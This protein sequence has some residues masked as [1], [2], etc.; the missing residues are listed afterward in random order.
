MAEKQATKKASS[1]TAKNQPETGNGYNVQP[2]PFDYLGLPRVAQAALDTNN[3]DSK[4][5]TAIYP[6]WNNV[7]H[8]ESTM[9]ICRYPQVR[10]SVRLRWE[11]TAGRA[12]TMTTGRTSIT[13]CRKAAVGIKPL[14][15]VTCRIT[16]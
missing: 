9:V 14:S 2:A 5:L 6:A 4:A 8:F 16:E 7:G 13:S 1:N 11:D 10:T 12:A 3:A 15:A